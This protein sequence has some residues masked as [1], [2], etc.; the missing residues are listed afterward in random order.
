MKRFF[1]YFL[2]FVF[3]SSYSSTWTPINDILE[4]NIYVDFESVSKDGDTFSFWVKRK[5]KSYKLILEF[6][7]I[8]CRNSKYKSNTIFITTN[9]SYQFKSEKWNLIHPRLFPIQISKKL[10]G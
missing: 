9:D 1:S 5:D 2:I 10:C 8:D 3:T 4:E 7:Q 6:Y